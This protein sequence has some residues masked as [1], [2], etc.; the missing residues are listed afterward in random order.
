MTLDTC[1]PNAYY[2]ILC[3]KGNQEFQQQLYLLGFWENEKIR[4][5]FTAPSGD[6]IAFEIKGSVMALRKSQLK[7]IH[8]LQDV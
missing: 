8:V 3:V 4:C 1:V 7:Q 6:P 2:R 5:V